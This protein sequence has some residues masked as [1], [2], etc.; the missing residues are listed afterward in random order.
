[1]SAIISPCGLYRYRLERTVAMEGPVYA[2]FGINPSTADANRDDATVRKWIGFTK[3]WGG[4][5]FIVGNVFAYR[6][7][8]VKQ[9][10]TV[11]DP[12]GPEIGD[13]LSSII[14]DADILVP[15]WGKTTKVPP[16]LLDA[17]AALIDALTSSG[18]PI[19]HFRL[20]TA[21]DPKHPLRLGYDTP[22]LAWSDA[23]IEGG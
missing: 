1:M 23:E 22:L 19:Q 13:H 2:F 17:F 4:S 5:R 7:T 9:L 10:A 12:Y 18:K 20:T 3:T 15:C 6:A 14:E 16:Q 21:G 8:D 11:E